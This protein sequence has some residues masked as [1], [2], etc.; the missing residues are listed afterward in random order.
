MNKI[1]FFIFLFFLSPCFSLE[2]AFQFDT[3]EK[4]KTYIEITEELRCLVCQN[5]SLLESQAGFA[6]D[7]RKQ[8]ALEVAQ[9]ENKEKIISSLKRVYGDYILYKPLLKKNTYFLWAFP[10]L[11]LF[12]G[13]CVL[14]MILR[15]SK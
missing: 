8:I 7:L 5:E 2:D 6:K 14:L 12:V 3:P 13:L 1:L 15:R 10:F 11:I 4:E 9:G